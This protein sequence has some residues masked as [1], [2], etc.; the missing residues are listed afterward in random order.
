[1][2]NTTTLFVEQLIIGILLLL[3]GAA[4][5]LGPD[6]LVKFLKDMKNAS[7]IIQGAAFVA[8]AYPLGILFDRIADTLTEGLYRHTVLALGRS[9]FKES[10]DDDPFPINVYRAEITKKGE[11]LT[12]YSDYLRHR[13]RILRS[14][15]MLLPAA[16]FLVLAANAQE[17]IDP[18]GTTKLADASRIVFEV[19]AV[20]L[21]WQLTRSLLTRY[22]VKSRRYMSFA[23]LA[24]PPK[25][26]A[27]KTVLDLYYQNVSSLFG[28]ARYVLLEPLFLIIGLL[29]Y[30]G[31]KLIAGSGTE[32]NY[33]YSAVTALALVAI[34]SWW[35]VSGT[36]LGYVRDVGSTGSPPK[37]PRMKPKST[38][39]K[40]KK[41]TSR[42][43]RK[44]QKRKTSKK[45]R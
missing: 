14:V 37:K 1:M 25:T 34:W 6:Q 9:R 31:E 10:Q 12:E 4:F 27:G 17:K 36:F 26:N 44:K 28:K 13:M 20:V 32:D 45:K 24:S 16:A 22:I 19:Y 42:K 21:L 5:I 30:K 3:T 35:R 33:L 23:W 2:K 29:Y 39:E 43:T 38:H 15:A 18:A 11:K 7:D 41:K 8:F 40:Q